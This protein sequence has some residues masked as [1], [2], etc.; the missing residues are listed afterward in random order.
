MYVCIV[1]HEGET[2]VHR[3]IPAKANDF[4]KIIEPYREDLAVA[5]ACMFT[6]YWLADLCLEAG[7]EFVLGHALNMKT[8]HGTKTKNERIDSEKIAAL[9]RGGYLPIAYV[10]PARMQS[11]RNRLRRRTFLVRKRAEIL[12]HIQNTNSQCNLRAPDPVT[13]SRL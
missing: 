9:L 6:W 13:G 4:L 1:N 5:A 3:T 12:G 7:I 8:I 2:L 10:Y 11:T